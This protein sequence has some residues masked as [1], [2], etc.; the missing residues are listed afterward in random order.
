[1]DEQY[2]NLLDS[3][4]GLKMIKKKY[5]VLVVVFG[6]LVAMLS[7]YVQDGSNIVLTVGILIMLLGL[8][9]ISTTIPDKTYDN[10]QI[11]E[12]EEE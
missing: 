8:F 9:R 3:P 10:E 12:D 11:I 1:M 5:S 4:T 7:S 2:L 6:F